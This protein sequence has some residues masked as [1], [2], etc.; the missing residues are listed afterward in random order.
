M[1]ELIK[2]FVTTF[3]LILFCSNGSIHEDARVVKINIWSMRMKHFQ[4][5]RYFVKIDK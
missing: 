1:M 5:N 4:T 3:F 2:D